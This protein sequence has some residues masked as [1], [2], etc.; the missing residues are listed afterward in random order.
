MAAILP[1]AGQSTGSSSASSPAGRLFRDFTR[2]QKAIWTSPFRMSKR[3]WVNTALPLA[4]GTAVLIATD[5]RAVDGLPNSN[6][7]VKW[8]G[9]VSHGG[10]LYTLAGAT[11]L[12]MVVGKLAHRPDA[13]QVG[14]SGTEALADAIVVT[15]ALK[16]AF[17]RERPDDKN[18]NA[19]FFHG[20][21]SFPSGHAVTV[22][23]AAVAVGRN[24]RTPRWLAVTGYAA[25][26]AVSLSRVGAR[27]H[28]PAD[29]LAGSAFGALIGGYVA[30]HSA[31]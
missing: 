19:R 17:G 10:A 23:A 16:Y 29:V 4:A 27:R 15:S 3:T 2:D 1:A 20:G 28:Y 7:Q 31:P 22:W 6:D 11:A 25:A 5:K 14:R 21:Q 26:T 18:S 30:R 9:R 12:P 24:R 13:V 8:S